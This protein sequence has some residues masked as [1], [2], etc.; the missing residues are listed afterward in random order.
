MLLTLVTHSMTILLFHS[1]MFEQEGFLSLNFIQAHTLALQ[2]SMDTFFSILEMGLIVFA[3]KAESNWQMQSGFFHYIYCQDGISMPR[4]GRFI[5]I[6]RRTLYNFRQAPSSKAKA[7]GSK[8]RPVMFSCGNCTQ[9]NTG[10]KGRGDSTHG[11]DAVMII[12]HPSWPFLSTSSHCQRL[13]MA[14]VLR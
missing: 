8:V 10:N 1:S 4:T 3:H 11:K 7:G 5:S 9:L 2:I 12:P 6:N 13:H 14:I